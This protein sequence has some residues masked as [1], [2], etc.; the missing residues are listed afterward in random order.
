MPLTGKNHI[1]SQLSAEGADLFFSVDPRSKTSRDLPFHSAT[2]NEVGRAVEAAVDAFREMRQY[3][4]GKLADFLDEIAA[5]IEAL[6]DDLLH[7][8]DGETG[9][10]LPR[11]TGERVRTTG[12]L[13][14]FA[15]LL[16]GGS[17]LRAIINSAAEGQPA[18]KQMQFPLGPVAVFAASNFPFAFAVAG[19]DTASALAAGCPVV[20][21]AHPGHPATSEL[22]AQALDA[23]VA[24]Q[25]LPAGAFSMLQG[26]G[27]DVG[28]WL[29]AHDGIEAVGFTGSLRGGRAI[30]DAAAARPRPIP[31]YAEMGSVNPVVI[32]QAALAARGE[33]I[34]DEL[35]ASVTMGAGQFCTNPGLILLEDSAAS[36]Q[37]MDAV[38]DKM[39]KAPQGVLL[40]QAVAQ[41]LS[42]AVS[43]TAAHA[44]IDIMT[45]AQAGS[46]GQSFCYSNTVMRTSAAAIRQDD[47]L[48]IEHFGPVTLFALCEDGAELR[49]TVDALE[50]NLTTTLHAEDSELDAIGDLLHQLREKAGRVI[51]NGFP[52]GVAVVPAMQ[53]GG[54]YPATTAPGTTSVGTNA[55]YRFMRPVAF[56]N[57]P[58][59][60]LPEALQDA[61]PLGI[62]R[63]VD[64]EYAALAV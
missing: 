62:L 13:R 64:G 29:V 4:P 24:A 51:W 12:Q 48:Q 30:Y 23:A 33:Q 57:V 11:L 38:S 26:Q 39:A 25:G 53:H 1:A 19:G 8:A 56:Q 5:Q 21:K 28:Q 6:G 43:Q 59:A 40:N 44:Q 58:D 16:R 34:A 49:E 32:T 37:F 10:G 42:G 31:V 60:L 27:I 41:G 18:I 52:T 3:P 2:R 50:G 7:T 15:S 63:L 9:L 17:Y 46:E 54:P 14:A 22:F 35:V 45:G 55:I 20:V 47:S 36:R 61:N